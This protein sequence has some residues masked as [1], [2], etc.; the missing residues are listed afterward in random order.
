MVDYLIWVILVSPLGDSAQPLLAGR[1]K[2]REFWD[3]FLHFGCLFDC[4]HGR[5][6]RIC[7]LNPVL[8]LSS[9]SSVI[10]EPFVLFGINPEME[11]LGFVPPGEDFQ[12]LCSLDSPK[13]LSEL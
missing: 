10:P 8:R 11:K 5:K 12:C 4:K 2:I 1:Q 3:F 9:G 13:S 6:I 7:D